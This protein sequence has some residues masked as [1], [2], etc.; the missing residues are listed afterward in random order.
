MNLPARGMW[1]AST[2]AAL[3]LAQCLRAEMR[4]AGVRVVNVFP[5]PV[6]HEWEQRT[7]PPRVA[8]AATA[9]AI[10]RA[11]KAGATRSA[12]FTLSEV[13]V[14]DR[15]AAWAIRQAV[16]ASNHAAYRYTATLGK[17][18]AD[19]AGL[20]QL[21][22]AGDDAQ[23]LAQGPAIA[24]GVEFARELGNLPP[25]YCTPAYLAEVGVKF[26]GEHDGA[27]AE[28]LDETQMEALGMGS[29]LAVARGS[30]NRPRLGVLKWTGAGDA[31]PYVLV[32]KGITF[33]TG[34]VNLQP[35]GG[36]EEMKP[37]C[38]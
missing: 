22:I 7:P 26:A 9:A 24:A 29:L 37:S 13:A 35:Q 36:I 11:L 2:A 1:S 19:D 17:K 28:I 32:G 31:K 10:V 30:A 21:A 25:N 8:P 20:A 4:G 6:D 33:D 18:K 34:G 3:S 16:I 15:D 5:G 12:L 27:E 14:K 23:A 38:R